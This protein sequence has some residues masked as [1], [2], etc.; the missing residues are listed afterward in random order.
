MIIK[1][2]FHEFDKCACCSQAK[3][4][5]TSHKSITRVTKLLEL[6][7]SNLCEFDDMITRNNKCIL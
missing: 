1:L 6:I 4:T 3:I 2:S 7:L 5:K